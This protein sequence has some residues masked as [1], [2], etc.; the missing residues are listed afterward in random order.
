ML[1]A[2]LIIFFLSVCSGCYTLEQAFRFNN[3]YNSRVPLRQMLEDPGL[4]KADQESLAL[5]SKT[6]AFAKAQ[7]LNVGKAYQY[8]IPDSHKPVSYSVQAAQPDRLELK[9]WWFPFAGTVPYLGYFDLQKRDEKAKELRAEGLDVSEGT[10]GAFSSLGWF[11]DPLYFSMLQ[12]SQADVVQLLLH[13][14]VHRSFWSQGSAAFNE[15]L[16]EFVSLKMTETYL[17]A[18]GASKE[19]LQFKRSLERQRIFRSWLMELKSNLSTLYARK[20]LPKE[21]ILEEKAKIIASF[22]TEKFPSEILPDYEAARK[23]PWNN[24]SILGS[25]LYLPDIEQFQRAWDCI[26]PADAGVYL[27][28]LKRAEAR[29]ESAEKA[30]KTLCPYESQ[31]S[32]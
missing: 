6:L 14:L 25:T 15:N 4:P 1:K 18:N 30:L 26:K 3:A 10:V 27:N 7:G 22:Q 11:A 5:A 29:S 12:R 24:A 2:C 17:L 31:T 32:I 21:K 23:K 19:W 13:E 20:D 16:A 9:T 28:A 8:V